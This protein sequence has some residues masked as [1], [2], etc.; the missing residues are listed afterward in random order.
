MKQI[1]IILIL[2]FITFQA[3]GQG[4]TQKHSENYRRIE[5]AIN[6][7]Y[8]NLDSALSLWHTAERHLKK[9]PNTIEEAYL[10]YVGAVLYRLQGDLAT[11]KKMAF[12]SLKLY[13]GEED[14]MGT[15]LALLE[16]G[17]NFLQSFLL[18]SAKV[19]FNRSLKIKDAIKDKAG[20]VIVYSNLGTI[21]DYKGNY[22]NASEYYLKSLKLNHDVGNKTQLSNTY[23][24]MSIVQYNLGFIDAAIDY[25]N[26]AV[27]INQEIDNKPNLGMNHVCLSSFYLEKSKLNKAAIHAEKAEQIGESI[28][29]TVMLL[30]A[31]SAEADILLKK[32][33]Y[34]AAINILDKALSS[35]DEYGGPFMKADFQFKKGKAL[36]LLHDCNHALPLYFKALKTFKT[37]QTA[38]ELK[39]TYEGIAMCFKAQSQPSK[40]LKYLEL[41]NTYRDSVFEQ[42][43]TKQLITAEAKFK[44]KEKEL[45]N[46]QLE[47]EKALQ[48]KTIS[49]Q[50]TIL[51]IVGIALALITILSILVYR[52]KN[53][54]QRLKEEAINNRDKIQ[55]LN[56]ELNHRVKNS[57]AFMTSL[58]EMQ[59]R[60][61]DNAETRQLL[62][63]SETRLKTLALVHS[64]LFKNEKDTEV[65]LNNYL[66]QLCNHLEDIFKIPDKELEIQTDFVEFA[67]N[68]EDAMRLGLIVNELITNSV[69]HAFADVDNPLV[70][71]STT[72]DDEGSLVLSYTDNGPGIP[73]TASSQKASSTSLGTKL[74]ALLSDQ[75]GDKYLIKL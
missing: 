67:I 61:T 75:L 25:Q 60:R 63:E 24:N 10:N 35:V 19:Y 2:S 20:K 37:Y 21:E 53:T 33:D 48:E 28:R 31:M 8:K 46:Q 64:N 44:A 26:K 18:D 51:W 43:K 6:L 47:A 5:D 50:K 74:I 54:Q 12:K 36:H 14:K 4:K 34:T 56:R 69:K 40:A 58:L 52:Q 23:H 39:Q 49:T 62:R 17:N 70:N 13:T 11:A 22:L 42:E 38:K 71:I 32:Q 45:K 29:D 55:I 16:I 73:E 15:S 59:G 30:Y 68:A 1:S 57:L 3:L 7:R 27:K 66:E 41:S 72:I 9:Q 65:D